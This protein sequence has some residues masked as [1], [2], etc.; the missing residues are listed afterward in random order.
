MNMAVKILKMV[1]ASFY[2][3]GHVQSTVFDHKEA[4]KKSLMNPITK[5]FILARYPMENEA[6][7]QLHQPSLTPM[8]F[9][10]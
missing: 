5:V 10:S 7:M 8:A 1:L 2:I 9:V 4:A 3:F 6:F